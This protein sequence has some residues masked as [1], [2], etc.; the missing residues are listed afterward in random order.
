MQTVL[1]IGT[2]ASPLAMAQAPEARDRLAA[3]HGLPDAAFEVVPITTSGDRIQDRTLAD[4]G[5]KGLFTKELEEALFDGRIDIAVHSSK[6]MPTLL[7]EG[8]E[9]SA[10]L[11]REDVRDAFLG[12]AA[13]RIAELPRGAR[14]G[15]SSRRGA[16]SRQCPDTPAQAGG[17]CR[18]R[19]RAGAGGP[20]AARPAASRH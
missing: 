5:G 13:P 1:K 12:K 6:D 9:L 15:S 7:P 17:G 2:R 16:V 3:A 8:L 10:F 11:P 18:G 14:V 19:H 4:S 20:Q